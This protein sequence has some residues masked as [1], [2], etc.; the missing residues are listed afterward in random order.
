VNAIGRR[1]DLGV[2]APRAAVA[3]AVLA[4]LA[5]GCGSSSPHPAAQAHSAVAF[6]RCM[7]SHGVPNFP[8]PLGNG[9][10]PSFR[11]GVS[12][13]V[14]SA[15]DSTCRHLLPSG[16]PVTPQEARQKLAFGL[17]VARCLR[18]HGY[19]GFPDPGSHSPKPRIDD[20]SPR[21]QVTETDCER[22]ARQA[23]HLP[24]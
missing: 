17:A 23:L 3:G 15:A 16:P 5:A 10:F 21:F 24:G 14:S 8:D 13:Q 9:R 4:L 12:K 20:T 6:A 22:R 18:A 2:L 11:A 19:P 1:R 7:R